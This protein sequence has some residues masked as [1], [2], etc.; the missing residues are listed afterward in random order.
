MDVGCCDSFPLMENSARCKDSQPANRL[1][2]QSTE[3][4]RKFMKTYQRGCRRDEG[5]NKNARL[6]GTAER[7]PV[8]L[9]RPNLAQVRN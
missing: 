5:N 2:T 7:R 1:V 6:G 4:T 9:K 8:S 3:M